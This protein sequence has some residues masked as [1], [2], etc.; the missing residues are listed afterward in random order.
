M[1]KKLR[2]FSTIIRETDNMIIPMDIRNSDYVQYLEWINAGNTA[3][4]VD[5]IPI[6]EVNPAHIE[7]NLIE[8]NTNIS[9]YVQSEETSHLFIDFNNTEVITVSI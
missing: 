2:N 7:F 4:E 3:E 6:T 8:L 1:Y 5:S 9:T